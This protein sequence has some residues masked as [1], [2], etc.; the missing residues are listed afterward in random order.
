MAAV[1]DYIPKF[2]Q[3]GKMKK[4]DIGDEWNLPLRK[5]IDIL[6]ALDRDEI[7]TIGFKAELDPSSAKQN[8]QNM[9]EKKSLDGV[10]L[11]I[12][13]QNNTFGG[14]N[15]SLEV[16]TKTE[17]KTIALNSKLEVS[18]QLLEILEEN[19]SD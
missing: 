1:S 9:L 5:N 12:L 19:F 10:C 7:F 15:N 8:A 6:D 4:D 18:M 3:E 13:D 17:T 2:P 16:I 11:N 14:E